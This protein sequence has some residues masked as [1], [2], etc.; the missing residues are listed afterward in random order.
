MKRSRKSN[1]HCFIFTSLVLNIILTVAGCAGHKVLVKPA[2]PEK[3]IHFSDLKG[4][5]ETRNLGGV[6][7]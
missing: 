7:L 6:G 4:W 3:M 1:H 2:E 5:D